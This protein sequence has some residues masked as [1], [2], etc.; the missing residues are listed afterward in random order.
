[1]KIKSIQQSVDAAYAHQGIIDLYVISSSDYSVPLPLA[2]PCIRLRWSEAH[3]CAKHKAN[4]FYFIY[5]PEI[6]SNGDDVSGGNGDDVMPFSYCALPQLF[7]CKLCKCLSCNPAF[8]R[9]TI[10]TNCT[11]YANFGIMV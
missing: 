8:H 5:P 2:N 1:M 9:I 6:A 4:V 11:A 3:V 10:A 7:I